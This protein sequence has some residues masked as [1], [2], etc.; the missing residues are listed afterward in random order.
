LDN[1]LTGINKY[2][3]EEEEDL[4]ELVSHK[5]LGVEYNRLSDECSNYFENVSKDVD[6]IQNEYVDFVIQKTNSVKSIAMNE[7]REGYKKLKESLFDVLDT[8]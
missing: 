7:D 3:G 5:D 1:A 2:F 4:T 6:S 8:A